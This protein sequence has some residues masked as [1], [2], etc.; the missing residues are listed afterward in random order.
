M[1]NSK[2]LS[3]LHK[4]A[5]G[6]EACLSKARHYLK[7]QLTIQIL[8]HINCVSLQPF[9]ILGDFRGAESSSFLSLEG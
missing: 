8:L 4:Y 1:E 5:E 6:N 2:D 9:K 7:V 3:L